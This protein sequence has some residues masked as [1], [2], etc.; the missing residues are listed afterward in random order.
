MAIVTDERFWDCEC[1]ERFIHSKGEAL[2]EVC[3]ARS[4]E[5]PDARVNEIEPRPGRAP[6]LANNAA[7]SMALLA[8]YKVEGLS[9]S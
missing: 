4:D 9:I 6:T 3:G 8:G 5:Q 2:C 7:I 1:E